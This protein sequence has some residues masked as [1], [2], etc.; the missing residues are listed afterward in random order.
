[1]A[2]KV[3]EKVVLSILKFLREELE[4]GTLS[5]DST[6]SLEVAVQCLESAY[7][8]GGTAA[9]ATNVPDLNEIFASN[10]DLWKDTEVPASSSSISESDKAEAEKLK[11]QGNTLLREEKYLEAME[12]YTKAIALNPTNPVYYSNRAATYSQL[13]RHN[14][15][16]QD[17]KKAL[18]LDPNYS[19]IYS[20]LGYA[21]TALNQHDNARDSYMK[22]WQLEPE[23][24][25]YRNNLSVANETLARERGSAIP[26]GGLGGGGLDLSSLMN[27][28]ALMNMASQML[29]NPNMQNLMSGIMNMGGGD[30][31][32]DAL[33]QAGQQLAQ[34]MQNTN[35]DLV[36][37][38]RRQMTNNP[39]DQRPPEDPATEK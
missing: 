11:G 39:E 31:N 19:K 12:C 25:T 21:Y 32:V 18:K 30:S 14:E 16:I 34:Q 4:N 27:N 7:N 17:C 9:T 1:M 26:A 20:R 5:E 10:P 37:N 35:P 23:N 6:E 3:T 2:D 36:E 33:I 22:A 15:T 13:N 24:E 28:P 29:S 38:L 8:L